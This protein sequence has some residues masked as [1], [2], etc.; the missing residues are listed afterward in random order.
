MQ[1]G[2]TEA[3]KTRYMKILGPIIDNNFRQQPSA[4]PAFAQ[5]TYQL[6]DEVA[7]NTARIIDFRRSDVPLSLIWGKYDPYLHVTAAEYMRSQARNATLHVLEAGHW[8]QIDEPAEVARLLI[9]SN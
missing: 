6:T 7:S 2:L 1:T 4:G 8:P 3:Q 5:M 9:A